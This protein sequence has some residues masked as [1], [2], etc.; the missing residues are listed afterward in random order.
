MDWRALFKVNILN[1]AEDYIKSNS[2]REFQISKGHITAE[3][4]GIENYHVKIGLV[5]N[6][7]PKMS[8]DCPYAEA[9]SNCKHMAA[10]MLVWENAISSEQGTRAEIYSGE[11]ETNANVTVDNNQDLNSSQE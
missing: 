2:V 5:E 4:A 8:C 3:V 7:A 9:G 11:E 10:V 6:E 1:G